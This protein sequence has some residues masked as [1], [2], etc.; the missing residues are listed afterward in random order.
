MFFGGNHEFVNSEKKLIDVGYRL[1]AAREQSAAYCNL[2]FRV[3]V[4]ANLTNGL[5]DRFHL[6]VCF[7]F[8]TCANQVDEFFATITGDAFAGDFV[9]D[10]LNQFA[11]GA[12]DLVAKLVIVLSVNLFK[13]VQVEHGDK[14]VVTVFP[15]SFVKELEQVSGLYRPVRESLTAR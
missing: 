12:N 15:D 4:E 13:I 2:Q 5:A 6:G 9:A 3:L 7:Y 11:Y 8:R 14:V 10:L 1:G